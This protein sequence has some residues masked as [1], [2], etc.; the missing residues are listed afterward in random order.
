MSKPIKCPSCGGDLYHYAG[1]GIGEHGDRIAQDSPPNP[2]AGTPNA[3]EEA[4]REMIATTVDYASDGPDGPK[5]YLHHVEGAADA[6]IAAARTQAFA[7]VRDEVVRRTNDAPVY[8]RNTTLAYVL[9]ALDAL[10][11]GP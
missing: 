9:A 10:E 8:V 7:E 5:A 2:P 4:R 6:L 11:R 3:V 1:C